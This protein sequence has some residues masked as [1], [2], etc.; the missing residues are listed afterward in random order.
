MEKLLKAEDLPLGRD[1]AITWFGSSPNREELARRV[2]PINYVRKDGP[3][4]FLIAGDKDPVLSY[5][6]SVWM[7]EALIK[8][9]QPTELHIVNGGSH[10]HFTPDQQIEIYGKILAFLK[11][12]GIETAP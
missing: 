7:H 12:N 11:K 4:V 10:G 8:A 6:Q 3:A 1:P 9:G 2:S 5:H